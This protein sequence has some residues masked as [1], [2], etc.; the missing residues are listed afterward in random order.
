ML[1][2]TEQH[3]AVKDAGMTM[4][5]FL[6]TGLRMRGTEGKSFNLLC[7]HS[8]A[9]LV[10]G[11]QQCGSG[12]TGSSGGREKAMPVFAFL[13]PSISPPR[14]QTTSCEMLLKI[15]GF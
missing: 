7:V 1:E 13:L 2:R 14:C 10:S 11:A 9:F 8:G 12:T 6:H 3:W 15:E 4:G 5:F